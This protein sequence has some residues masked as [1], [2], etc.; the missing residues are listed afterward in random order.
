MLLYAT[1][2]HNHLSIF[3]FIM[4]LC[5]KQPVS[6]MRLV[7]PSKTAPTILPLRCQ[8]IVPSFRA[9]FILL[10]FIIVS[11]F[12]IFY[13]SALAKCSSTKFFLQTSQ[14][15][16]GTYG[17]T[18]VFANYILRNCW[19]SGQGTSLLVWKLLVLYISSESKKNDRNWFF[20]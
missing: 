4:Y 7:S 19:T 18:G 20:L 13:Q 17:G 6:T 8:I 2:W 11:H 16:W 9:F 12:S 10:F 15:K 5:H 3:Q 14:N 1:I